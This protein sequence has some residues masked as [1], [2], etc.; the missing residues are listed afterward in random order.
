MHFTQTHSHLFY[1]LQ[2]SA[3]VTNKKT[4]IYTSV[5]LQYYEYTSTQLKWHQSSDSLS[6]SKS[7]QN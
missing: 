6:N 7:E 5:F 2:S 3:T 1:F 4:N